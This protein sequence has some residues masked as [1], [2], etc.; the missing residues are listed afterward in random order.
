MGKY[1]IEVTRTTTRVK[2]FEVEAMSASEA[3]DRAEQ[4]AYDYDFNEV[5]G[6][7]EYESMVEESPEDRGECPECGGKIKRD[8]LECSDE[9]SLEEGPKHCTECDWKE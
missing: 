4:M 5:T 3:I 9:T 6:T 2:T 1:K 7:S 8:I